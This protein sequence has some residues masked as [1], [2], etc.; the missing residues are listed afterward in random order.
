MELFSTSALAELQN[1]P[2]RFQAAS[3][4]VE[5]QSRLVACDL[6]VVDQLR[7]LKASKSRECFELD[8]HRVEANEVWSVIFSQ[9]FIFV[10]DSKFQLG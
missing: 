4:E 7:F 2:P 9:T 1:E 8:N 3:T 10:I 6:Q 5:Q